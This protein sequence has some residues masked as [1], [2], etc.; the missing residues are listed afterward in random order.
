MLE[1]QKDRPH[2]YLFTKNK[3]IRP[4]KLAKEIKLNIKV[5]DSKKRL[6]KVINTTFITLIMLFY[7]LL[8]IVILSVPIDID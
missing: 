7:I 4:T 1:W 5:T 6:T 8:F 2:N 3:P